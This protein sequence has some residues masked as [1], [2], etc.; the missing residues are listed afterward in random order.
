MDARLDQ[1]PG[2]SRAARLTGQAAALGAPADYR[3]CP[4]VLFSK[5]NQYPESV[6][7]FYYYYIM[8]CE[9]TIYDL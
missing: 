3:Y 9:A 4:F 2:Q 5:H 1:P 8:I 6:T 7:G